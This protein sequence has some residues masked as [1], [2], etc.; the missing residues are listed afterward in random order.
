M[1]FDRVCEVCKNPFQV[2][3][4]TRKGRFCSKVC[5]DEWQRTAPIEERYGEEGAKRMRETRRREWIDN[6]PNNNPDVL[7]I[8]SAK[9]TEYRKAHPLNGVKN[10]FF[11]R[12]HS[13]DLKNRYRR[14]RTGKRSYND[15][16][17]ARQNAN[18]LRGE[19]HPMWK[20]GISGQPRVGFTRRLKDKIRQRDGNICVMCGMV[21]KKA[22]LPV[23]HIDYD[24]NNQSSSNLISLCAKCHGKTNVNRSEWTRYFTTNYKHL[25][26]TK[27]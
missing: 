6:N 23:H 20:G 25:L 7:A 3:C 14:D 13:V 2:L 5:M 12:T 24:K 17:F 26:E 4:R 11:G 22:G 15:V 8:K 9:A 10:P 1:P 18:T 21:R 27:I 16:Q 19:N